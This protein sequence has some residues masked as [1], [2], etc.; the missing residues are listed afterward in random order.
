MDYDGEKVRIINVP[1]INFYLIISR[2]E[3]KPIGYCGISDCKELLGLF[4]E[5]SYRRKGFASDVVKT[6]EKHFDIHITT[7]V[8]NM[9][10]QKLCEKLGYVK[11]LK[12]EKE[13]K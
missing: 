5:P 1:N 8:R 10:M 6:L 2:A 11:W 12:Y 13:K 4:I 7:H 3:H 9:P